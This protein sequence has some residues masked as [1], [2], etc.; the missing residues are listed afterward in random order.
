MGISAVHVERVRRTSNEWKE[1]KHGAYGDNRLAPKNLRTCSD[2][3]NARFVRQGIGEAARTYEG[4]RAQKLSA[5]LA[6]AVCDDT[7]I[8]TR[9]K[10]LRR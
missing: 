7:A 1:P 4:C 10:D 3:P 5:A 6:L 9:N 8:S 2:R